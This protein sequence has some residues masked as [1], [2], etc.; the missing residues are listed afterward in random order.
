MIGR[1]FGLPL[2]E[3][4]VPREQADPGAVRAAAARSR[5]RGAR[6]PAPEYRFRHGLVQEVAY[7]SLV[8]GKRRRLHRQVGE[9]LEAARSATRRERGLRLLARHFSEAD[10]PE[11][12]AEYLLKAGDAARALYADQEALEHYSRARV[13]LARMGD[14]RRARDTLFKMALAHHL[15]FDFERAEEVLRRGVLLPG[16]RRAA[17]YRPSASRPSFHR[18]STLSPG[19]VYSTDEMQIAEHL[20]RGLLTVDEETNVLPDLADNFRVSKDGRTYLFRL[21][22][23]LR[24]SD[25]VPLTAEDFAYA[26]RRIARTGS[27]WRSMLADVEAAEALD[28]RTLEVRC[29]SRAATSRTSSLR[30][31]RS[32]GPAPC[33]R[34]ATPGASPRIS[35]ATARSCIDE[36]GRAAR[37]L[38]ANPH[39]DGPARQRA[40]GTRRR[41]SAGGPSAL[42]SGVTAARRPPGVDPR[43]RRRAET[44][45]PRSSR[46]SACTTSAPAPTGRRSRT[47]SCAGVRARGRPP[48]AHGRASSLVAAGGTRRRDPAGDAGPLPPRR[49]SST[50]PSWRGACSPRR[51][52]PAARACP[53]SRSSRAAVACDPLDAPRRAM[54]EAIGAR[55]TVREGGDTARYRLARRSATSGSSAG[56]PTIPIPTASSAAS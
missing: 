29:A 42:A 35:S 38:V 23:G 17:S 41:S 7:A 25:G 3:R 53:S 5:R 54:A 27:E 20:F 9:A 44:R 49:R 31:G 1:S 13:F 56:R 36:L 11:K 2:L 15:A 28:D 34:S 24:W 47:S 40:R 43:V 26:W 12:A 19:D 14:D 45:S 46:S 10:E 18:P 30:P 33:E 55:I 22:E 39:W 4:L 51:A 6:R 8:D 32:R 37:L 21:R 50:T 16:G 48:S 52:I